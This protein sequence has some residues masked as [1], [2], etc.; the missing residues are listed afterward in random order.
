MQATVETQQACYLPLSSDGSPV[1]GAVPGA[2]GV[3]IATGHSCW[4][5]LN[6]PAT[7]LALAELIVQ[8]KSTSVDIKAFSPSRFVRGTK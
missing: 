2:A 5:I 1:I 7:G 8:G 6:G 3:F 4:G